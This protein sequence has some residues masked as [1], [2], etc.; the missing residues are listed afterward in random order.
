MGC[1][2][3]WVDMLVGMQGL[4]N[5]VI[6]GPV[7]SCL[8]KCFSAVHHTI[9]KDKSLDYLKQVLLLVAFEDFMH[10]S[11][12]DKMVFCLGEKQGMIAYDDCSPWYNI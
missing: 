5:G 10:H 9:P 7:K 12:L 8:S 1:L 11:I 6:V 2:I 3:N 4:R